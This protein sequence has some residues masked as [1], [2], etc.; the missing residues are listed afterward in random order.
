LEEDQGSWILYSQ[1]ADATAAWHDSHDDP[2]FLYRG[3]QL[4]ALQ[5]AAVRWSANPARSPVLTGTQRDFLA[6]SERSGVRSSR[7]RRSAIAVLALLTVLALAATGVAF[8]L[9]A[10]ADQQ[11]DQANYNEVI[12]EA[13]Q[14][15]TS[16]S[17]LAAQ[18]MLAA[19]RIQPTQDLA[20]RLLNTENIPLS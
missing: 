5:Q 7:L 1:L 11:R 3:G 19:Y 20:S 18:L 17:T 2:S 15:G 10:V 6:A 8:Y 14:Y 13:L 12:A 9:R 4:A 16:D